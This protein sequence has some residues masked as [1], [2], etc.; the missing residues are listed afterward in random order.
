[1][2]IVINE[3]A[4]DDYVMVYEDDGAEIADPT[5]YSVQGDMSLQ[6]VISGIDKTEENKFD[7]NIIALTGVRCIYN[8]NE[9]VEFI[10]DVVRVTY[11]WSDD[12]TWEG[13][14]AYPTTGNDF[15]VP[16]DW[17]LIIDIAETPRMRHLQI[18]GGLYFSNT[19]DIHLRAE[20]IFNRGGDFVVGTEEEPYE[21]TGLIT[22]FG[23]RNADPIAFDSNI[24]AGNKVIANVG[25]MEI[26]GIE[27][28]MTM[29]RLVESATNGDSTI[30]LETG[31]DWVAGDEIGLA[32]TSYTPEAYDSA[33]IES[34]DS[35]TGECVLDST[36]NFYHYG[37]A[38]AGETGI[39]MRC[40]VLLFTRNIKIEG[41]DVDNWGCAIITSDTEEFAADESVIERTGEL[42]MHN[43]EINRCSQQDTLAA[44]VRFEAATTYASEVKNCAFHHGLSWGASI[45]SSSEITLEN[46]IFFAFRPIGIAIDY[47][48]DIYI[49]SNV[50]V[51]IVERSTFVAEHTLDKRGGILVC[52]MYG[53]E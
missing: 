49:E 47:S 16:Q 5:E 6:F 44:A 41:E 22:L 52:G 27:R 8:C 53:W 29:T 28:T 2:H 39:D 33:F 43:V 11:Y 51:G 7:Q 31:L 32:P 23:S 4:T 3:T 45:R 25:Y 12:A 36:L 50:V 21:Y 48:D 20:T 35:D 1:M 18:L 38:D 26:V 34:Y 30:Y 24:E 10:E 13:D 14:T 17:D 15:V 19:M 40:E 42:I 9:A 37:A 46:N